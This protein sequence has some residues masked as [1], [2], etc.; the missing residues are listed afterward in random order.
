LQDV[1]L[2]HDEQLDQQSTHKFNVE[3]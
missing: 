2:L 3:L 1:A